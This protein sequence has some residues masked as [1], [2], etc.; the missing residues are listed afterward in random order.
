MIAYIGS[1][2]SISSLE[3][4]DTEST[5]NTIDGVTSGFSYII[6]YMLNFRKTFIFFLFEHFALLMGLEL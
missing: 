2:L 1:N 5:L 3:H 4:H 6:A